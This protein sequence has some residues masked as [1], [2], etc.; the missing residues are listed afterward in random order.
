VPRHHQNWIT[1]YVAKVKPRSEAPERYLYW[2]AV[3]AIGG[4]LRR[5][6]YIDMGTFKWH[7]NWFIIF[8]GPPGLVK[9]STTVDIAMGLLREVPG[10]NFGS[11]INTWEGF[12]EEFEHSKDAFAT[13][14]AGADI[15]TQDYEMTCAV[16]LAISEWGMFLDPKNYLMVN[17]LTDLWDCKDTSL[18]KN[19]KTQGSNTITAPFLNMIAGTTP[20]WMNDN[21]RFSGWGFSARCIFL[22]CD[23]PEQSIP[24][25]D[26]LWG[27]E[28]KTWRQ[29]FIDDLV[30]ISE[31]EGEIVL[32][33]EAREF[34]KQWYAANQAR[35][36][37]FA[38]HPNA[39]PWIAEYLARKQTHIHKLCICLSVAKGDSHVIDLQTIREATRR[40]NEVEEELSKIFGS[41][42]S[43]SKVARL[44]R[45]VWN[46]LQNI[47]HKAGAGGI[48]ERQ[49][50]QFTFQYMS[51]GEARD[52]LAQLIQMDYIEKAVD[53]SN[54]GR[55]QTWIRLGEKGM[56]ES[57][58][59][60][61]VSGPA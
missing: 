23:T 7:P 15:M 26:E 28:I 36:T 11:D 4:A 29:P 9:K 56:P 41:R 25:P 35:I 31:M 49:A 40:V 61:E 12:I 57:A 30:E 45:D 38:S 22:H 54:P 33:P 51:Q 48:T 60:G 53:I 42:R 44:N 32:S 47:L 39:D 46:G 43:E 8:V 59:N 17:V 6:C 50:I 27:D 55:P 5:R 58:Q 20:R 24:Y 1:D 3:A 16:T 19:T 2:S 37:A 13:G 52:L 18:K 34:G 14:G 10:V 21:F